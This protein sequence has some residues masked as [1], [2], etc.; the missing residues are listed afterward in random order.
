MKKETAFA[1]PFRAL[2]YSVSFPAGIALLLYMRMHFG[3]NFVLL[4]RL[5]VFIFSIGLA[6]LLCDL[7][8]PEFINGPSQVLRRQSIFLDV[9]ALSAGS[10]MYL[11]IWGD[12][13]LIIV[14]GLGVSLW[15][16]VHLEFL[17]LRAGQTDVSIKNAS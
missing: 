13:G 17:K 4:P 6:H 16:Y 1:E 7:F 14:T 8:L 3:Y 2:L 9:W 15:S 5:G 10:W 12:I 11:Q